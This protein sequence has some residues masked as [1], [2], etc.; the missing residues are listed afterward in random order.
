MKKSLELKIVERELKEK[1][2]RNANKKFR[3][4]TNKRKPKARTKTHRRTK[5]YESEC[6]DYGFAPFDF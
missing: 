4:E 2:Q 1:K 6:D 5:K 3:L